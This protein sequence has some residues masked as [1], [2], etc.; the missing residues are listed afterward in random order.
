M[1][2]QHR[3]PNSMAELRDSGEAKARPTR[4][5]QGATACGASSRGWR[6]VSFL[7]AVALIPWT[8][9]GWQLVALRLS[10]ALALH[11]LDLVLKRALRLGSRAGGV[12][13]L[14]GAICEGWRGVPIMDAGWVFFACVRRGI[15]CVLCHALRGARPVPVERRLP[16]AA[17]SPIG[18]PKEAPSINW[19][20]SRR[21]DERPSSDLCC[22]VLLR[23]LSRDRGTH[24]RRQ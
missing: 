3:I 18:E 15:G 4:R 11:R 20:W 21:K 23:R 16:G 5:R 1:P 6:D 10:L 14:L 9:F 12:L 2:E 13:A 19:S 17:C 22:R 7:P 24:S 8:L